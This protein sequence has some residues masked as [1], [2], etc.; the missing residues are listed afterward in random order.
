MRKIA[1]SRILK[2]PGPLSQAMG[3]ELFRILEIA[4][5]PIFE[6]VTLRYWGQVEDGGLSFGKFYISRSCEED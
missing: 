4:N 2:S 3:S 5:S 1:L 6:F